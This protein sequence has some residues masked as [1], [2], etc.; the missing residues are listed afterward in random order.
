MVT[1]DYVTLAS[2]LARSF[3]AG[4]IGDHGGF[5]AAAKKKENNKNKNNNNNKNKNNNKG[6]GGGGKKK[7]DNKNKGG[8]KNNNNNNNN[9]PSHVQPAS[10][11]LIWS[12]VT[13]F[14]SIYQLPW[15]SK[16]L[17]PHAAWEYGS[18]WLQ[19]SA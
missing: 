1:A 5:V 12:G 11:S 19:E 18:H 14:G 13:S 3:A 16:A 7:D 15:S 8:G 6:G 10:Q 9:S 4:L 2:Y 17:I